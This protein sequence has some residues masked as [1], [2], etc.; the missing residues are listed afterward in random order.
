MACCAVAP[1]LTGI[2]ARPVR[3]M[4]LRRDGAKTSVSACPS[5]VSETPRTGPPTGAIWPCRR[6][7]RTPPRAMPAAAS[8]GAPAI[9]PAYLRPAWS[10][11]AAGPA[12]NLP[13]PAMS[14]A[15]ATS[16]YKP[17]SVRTSGKLGLNGVPKAR[18]AVPIPC[19]PSSASWRSTRCC[20]SR[21]AC[22]SGVSVWRIV[23]MSP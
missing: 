13:M 8:S 20:A 12:W 3:S 6:G 7:A 2:R 21:V 14:G 17:R 4:S 11:G 15:R 9:S 16:P 18:C 5:S 19:S 22:D 1:A 10:E 23:G